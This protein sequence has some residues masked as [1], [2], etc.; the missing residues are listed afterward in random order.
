MTTH[1]DLDRS[2]SAWLVSEAPARAPDHLVEAS[3]VRIRSTRQR[4]SGWQPRLLWPTPRIDQWR[5]YASLAVAAAAVVVIAVVGTSVAPTVPKAGSVP[6]LS[7]AQT[8][9][10]AS[11]SATARPSQVGLPPEGATP[12]VPERGELVLRLEGT[13]SGPLSMLWVYDDGRMIWHRFR[14]VPEDRIPGSIGLYEQRLTPEGIAFLRSEILSSGLFDRDLARAREG[15]APFLEIEV[16]NGARLIRATWATRENWKIGQT[17]PIAT[18]EEARKLTAL[19][20]LLRDPSSWPSS[21]WQDRAIKG[22]VP[23][24]YAICFRGVPQEIE[25]T[26]ILS[27]LP[28]SAQLLLRSLPANGNCSLVLTADARTLAQILDDAGIRRAQGSSGRVWVRYLLRPAGGPDEVWI[29]FAPVLPHG[30]AT[31]LGPG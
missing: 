4:R 12:S 28:T 16:R 1:P 24:R 2:I 27:L 25:P 22:Y 3:R 7:S 19:S 11:P 9:A 20:A 6:G 15:R 17:A 31:F 23:T 14:G 8:S 30:D 29:S 26:R 13:A 18:E 5:S 10:S 21:A